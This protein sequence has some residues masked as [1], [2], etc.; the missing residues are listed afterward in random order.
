MDENKQQFECS[1]CHR[2]LINQRNLDAHQKICEMTIN[3]G[4]ILFQCMKIFN[5]LSVLLVTEI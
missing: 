4:I 5:S 2:N 1:K 3:Q